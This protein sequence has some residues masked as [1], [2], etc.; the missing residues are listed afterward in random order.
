MTTFSTPP[1][2]PASSRI[3]ASASIDSGVCLAGLTTIV[4]PA[5]IAGPI[6]RVP[7]ASG[8]FHG[9]MN[10]HG[11]TG[12]CIVST[13]PGARLVDREAAVDAHRLLGVPAEEVGGVGDLGLGL[14]D[15]LA[16]LERHQQ[17]EVVG[18]LDD[19]VVGAAQDVAALARGDVA[20]RRRTS[21]WAAVSAAL[22]SSTVASATSASVSPVDG[23]ST[24]SVAPAGVAPLAADEQ[25]GLDRV[26]DRLLCVALMP[27]TL[28][29][30][31]ARRTRE[32]G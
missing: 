14:G 3:W 29:T 22:A 11:P 13:R 28:P 17:R 21:S 1:G 5:A 31:R 15:R 24:V 25:L 32:P 4:Q 10:T 23:S 2:S 6:L 19:R 16:H 9:V 12:C 20:P 27:S 7:I 30:A 8:K 26:E 18:A